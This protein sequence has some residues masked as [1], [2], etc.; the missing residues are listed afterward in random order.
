MDIDTGNGSSGARGREAA[1]DDYQFYYDHASGRHILYRDQSP[2]PPRYSF[3]CI[4]CNL[5]DVIIVIGCIAFLYFAVTYA[6]DLL[7]DGG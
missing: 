5:V 7:E 6:F 2:R 3:K 4:I 1:H